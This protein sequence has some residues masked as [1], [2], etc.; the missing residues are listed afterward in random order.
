MPNSKFWSSKTAKNARFEALNSI[1]LISQ[2]IWV[3][4]KLLN[5]HTFSKMKSFSILEML[6]SK[7]QSQNFKFCNFSL[8]IFPFS[9]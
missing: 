3:A 2:K 4:E 1:E 9:F 7:L 5:F 8:L 6:E